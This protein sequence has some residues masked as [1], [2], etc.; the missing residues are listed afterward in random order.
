M[1][2]M[3]AI[4]DGDD[5]VPG[6]LITPHGNREC[7]SKCFSTIGCNSWTFSSSNNSCFLKSDEKDWKF[8]LKTY[9]ARW[10]A[11]GMQRVKKGMSDWTSG[12][13]QCGS[14]CKYA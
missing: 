9:D 3:A 6:G 12:N 13:K 1:K 5:L 8:D 2:Y 14:F 4:I 11:V 10:E 7:A